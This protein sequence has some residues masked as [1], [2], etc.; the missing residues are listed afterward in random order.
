MITY[1][2]SA[3]LSNTIQIPQ[4]SDNADAN[5]V[6][7]AAKAELDNQV[8]LLT[9][10]SQI[11]SSTSPIRIDSV[12][13]IDIVV[14][15]L[16]NVLVQASGTWTILT[17][18][19][20][21][22]INAANIEGG[23]AFDTNKWY[24]IYVWS[25][26]G[27]PQFQLSIIP[28]DGYGLYKNG[29]FG[30]KYLG[31]VRTDGASNVLSFHKYNG[32]T[33]YSQIYSIGTG[34]SSTRTSLGASNYIPPTA[35]MGKFCILLNTTPGGLA[36][37]LRLYEDNVTTAYTSI[38]YPANSY[39]SLY[40]DHTVDISQTLYYNVPVFTGTLGISYYCQGYYE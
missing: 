16:S 5:S 29:S 40:L 18:A 21:T 38:T 6:N 23:G 31:S 27:V 35:R 34:S 2:G 19:L 1:T 10:Y 36:G 9:L 26:A 15:P 8:T 25:L 13:G 17:T 11:M 14:G 24:Y 12:N 32:V 4:D 33:L 39:Q 20:S 28:P 37:E 22:T 30:Y 7:L 3:N